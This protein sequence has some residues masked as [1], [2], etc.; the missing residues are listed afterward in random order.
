MYNK[1]SRLEQHIDVDD[2][3]ANL[4]WYRGWSKN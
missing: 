4:L 3:S 1:D 2:S